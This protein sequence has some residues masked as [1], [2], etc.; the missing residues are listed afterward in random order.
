MG[1]AE[2]KERQ[3]AEMREQILQAAR[4]IVLREGFDALTMRKIADT[5]EYSPAT[6][7]LHFASRDEIAR[8]LVESG[9]AELIAYFGPV[10]AIAD[11]SE[12]LSAIG[13]AYVTF[14]IE[15]P[16]TY[17][18]IFMENYTSAVMGGEKLEDP[19]EPGTRAFG[20]VEQTVR[21]LV[22]RGTI[23]PIDPALG[24]EMLWA[25]VH[26]IV[27][28]KLVCPDFPTHSA[29]ALAD[30]MLATLD[31]GLRATKPARPGL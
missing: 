14:G 19:D 23:A 11:P 24:A 22:E 28:L 18:L 30:T 20:F 29:Q 6:I 13:R 5:I 21:E 7:Y 25:A 16:Q 9:F 12:R 31:A 4:E 17:R 2:R 10:A 3:K 8:H 27:S 15:H 1:I 26:G